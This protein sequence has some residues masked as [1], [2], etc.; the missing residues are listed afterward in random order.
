MIGY[1]SCTLHRFRVRVEGRSTWLWAAEVE[2]IADASADTYTH[3]GATYDLSA[4]YKDKDGDIWRF[5]RCADGTTEGQ[6]SAWDTDRWSSAYSLAY[7]ASR[8]GPLTRI[9]S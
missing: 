1:G 6:L 4:R 2:R 8:Y 5:R 3:D 9:N 7:V